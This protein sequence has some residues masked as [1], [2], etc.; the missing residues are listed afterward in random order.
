[1]YRA[2][3]DGN[4]GRTRPF[5]SSNMRLR[6]LCPSRRMPDS[7]PTLRTG[8]RG[9]RAGIVVR[10]KCSTSQ[11]APNR[12]GEN[13]ARATDSNR[14]TSDRQWGG[15][16][17]V[18]RGGGSLRLSREPVVFDEASSWQPKSIRPAPPL[19][20]EWMLK[21]RITDGLCNGTP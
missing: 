19:R 21:L 11:D 7:S 4:C 12:S 8:H 1:M 20:K 6:Q 2:G 17:K 3:G 13:Q 10:V 16:V 14:S 5:L 15:D 9:L 18:G